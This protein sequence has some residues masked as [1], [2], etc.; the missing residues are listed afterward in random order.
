MNEVLFAPGDTVRH[1]YFPDDAVVSLLFDVD[2]R[3]TVEVAMESSGEASQAEPDRL[4]SGANRNSGPTRAACDLLLLLRDHQTPIRQPSQID[5]SG[6]ADAASI[7]GIAHILQRSLSWTA[8]VD[9]EPGSI[10]N[11]SSWIEIWA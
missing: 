1:I 11:R 10:M 7:T 4:P 3:R 2:E 9:A 5:K 6:L 8:L